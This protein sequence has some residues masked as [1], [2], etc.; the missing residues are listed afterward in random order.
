MEQPSSPSYASSSDN[1][2]TSKVC[3]W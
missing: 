3:P 1:I 2:P